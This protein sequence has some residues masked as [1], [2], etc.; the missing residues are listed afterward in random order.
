MVNETTG[1]I[2]IYISSSMK[3]SL[4]LWYASVFTCSNSY[5]I[6]YREIHL[7]M[8]IHW[9]QSR[10]S[11]DNVGTISLSGNPRKGMIL[12]GLH[13]KKSNQESSPDLFYYLI[14]YGRLSIYHLLLLLLKHKWSLIPYEF[15]MLHSTFS[16]EKILSDDLLSHFYPKPRGEKEYLWKSDRSAVHSFHPKWRW[17]AW[18]KYARIILFDFL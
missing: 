8:C 5:L 10:H 16:P 14:F 18:G 1:N 11:I 2:I 15:R 9:F 7:D 13:C 4:C 3:R 6:R 17:A 12:F